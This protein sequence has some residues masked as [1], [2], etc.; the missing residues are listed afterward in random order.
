[1]DNDDDNRDEWFIES[2]ILI[3]YHCKNGNEKQKIDRVDTLKIIK[4]WIV[5]QNQFETNK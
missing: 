2:T 1:M 4:S 5:I 3:K